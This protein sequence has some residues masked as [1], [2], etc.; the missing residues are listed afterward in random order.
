MRDI[1]MRA[2]DT[3]RMRGAS[4]A[5]VRLVQFKAEHVVV[6]N[7]NVE[8]L[9]VE[10]SMGFGVRVIVDGYWGFAS[11]SRLASRSTRPSSSAKP[12]ALG[13]KSLQSRR[14]GGSRKAGS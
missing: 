3:A 14:P 5:D 9:V 8:A 6:R 11:S 4:Y 10:E 13:E 12:K 7:R 2:L 1:V